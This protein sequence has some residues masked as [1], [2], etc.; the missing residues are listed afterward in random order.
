[1]DEKTFLIRSVYD[2]KT[3]TAMCHAMRKTLKRGWSIAV[4]IFLWSCIIAVTVLNL[5]LAI[6]GA[7]VFDFDE[8]LVLLVVA[9]ML[10]FVL[11][12]D[13]LNAWIAALNLVPGSKD[14]QTRFLD[15]EYV[16]TNDAAVTQ[17]P[18]E[19]IGTVCELKDYFVFFLGKRHGQ[20]YPKSGFLEGTPED[21]R[22]FITEKTGKEIRH[23]K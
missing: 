4:R 20:V 6:M 5:L 17:L 18:Y 21:F 3:L 12:E 22:S 15:T 9:V 10:A 23:V 14:S 19:K 1:M 13:H 2:H 8:F 16:C 7:F 11:G